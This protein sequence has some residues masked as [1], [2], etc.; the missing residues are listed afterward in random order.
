MNDHTQNFGSK[1]L[2]EPEFNSMNFSNIAQDNSPCNPISQECHYELKKVS[3][4]S[5]VS[6][7]RE[8]ELKVSVPTF[9]LMEF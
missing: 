7:S 6:N 4:D 8:A 1:N 9:R 3:S 2:L 5:N